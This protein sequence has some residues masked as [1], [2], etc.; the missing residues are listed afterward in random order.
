MEEWDPNDKTQSSIFVVDCSDFIEMDVTTIQDIFQ[1]RDIL[2]LGTGQ[3]E[4]PFSLNALSKL[5]RLD[6]IIEMQGRSLQ[7]DFVILY[8]FAG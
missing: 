1:H 4:E 6:R 7:S 5:G 3:K 8:V 2:V